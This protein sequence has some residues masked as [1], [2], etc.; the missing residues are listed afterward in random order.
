MLITFRSD[1]SKLPDLPFP[2]R[3][4]SR[5]LL[6]LPQR[7]PRGLLLPMQPELWAQVQVQVPPQEPPLQRS[8]ALQRVQEPERKRKSQALQPEPVQAL[9]PRI[10][11]AQ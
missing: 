7:V 6:L 3:D 2:R 10:F 9:R 8:R 11:A 5:L 4:C 1:R